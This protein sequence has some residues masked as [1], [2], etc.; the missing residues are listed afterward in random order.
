MEAGGTDSALLNP[1]VP[2]ALA[3]WRTVM[4]TAWDTAKSLADKHT[5]AGGIFIR[6]ANDGDHV[7]GAFCGEPDAR[8]VHWTGE[9]YEE[10]A[11]MRCSHCANGSK[12][13]LRVTLNFWV[14]AENAMKVMEGGTMW[15]RDVV[16]VKDKY[17]LDKWIF[18]VK[19][20]GKAKDPRTKYVI[21]PEDRIDEETRK[22]ISACRQ[23][24]LIGL[25]R[26]DAYE[27]PDT[28]RPA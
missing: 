11:R 22:K 24:D 13:S 4:T 15:F 7:V 21:L 14:A 23:H 18:D 28:V 3:S 19:R 1:E 26:G 10:C 12:P 25:G 6:L 8:E 9:K 17:G 20:V 2:E 5:S 16:A 27:V